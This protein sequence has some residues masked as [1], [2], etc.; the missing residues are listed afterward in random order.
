VI[1]QDE[2]RAFHLFV[3]HSYAMMPLIFEA[4]VEGIVS[5]S[6]GDIAL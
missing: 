4:D 2:A 6:I 1:V 5:P 3:G